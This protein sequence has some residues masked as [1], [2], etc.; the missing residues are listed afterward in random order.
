MRP[1]T[2][3]IGILLGSSASMTFGLAAVLAVFCI[4]LRTHPDLTSELPHLLAGTLVFALLTAASAGSFLGQLHIR[5]WRG[6]AHLATG[7]CFL[8]VVFLYWPRRS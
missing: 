1:F 5:P 8:L 3:L 7:A 6:W 2:V 4:L